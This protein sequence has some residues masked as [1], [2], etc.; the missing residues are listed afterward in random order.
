MAEDK[1]KISRSDITSLLAVIFSIAALVVSV[2]QARIMADQQ[3][4]MVAQQKAA[5]WPYVEVRNGLNLADSLVYSVVAEN[6]GVGPAIVQ[7]LSIEIQGNVYDNF[8]DFSKALTGLIGEEG[9][10]VTRF[11]ITQK[12]K[13]VYKPGE[14]RVLFEVNIYN[15]DGYRDKV[16]SFNVNLTY[17][18]IYDDCWFKNGK[19]LPPDS[20]TD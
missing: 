7:G 13:N 20:T 18:S 15:V 11:G 14:S 2:I 1:R 6:K 10:M 3:T 17:C 5:V 8:D 16:G 9:Y 12:R 19:P 4:V